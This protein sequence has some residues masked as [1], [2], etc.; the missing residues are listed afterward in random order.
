ML[1]L[2]SNPFGP[3]TV[4]WRRALI[5]AACLEVVL[6]GGVAV[7]ILTPG[8]DNPLPILLALALQFPGSLLFTPLL[9]AL[10]ELFHSNAVSVVTSVLVVVLVEFSIFAVL[11]K[12]P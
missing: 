9:S 8:A 12:R 7:S 5:Q 1:G 6:A 11:F 3:Q 4:S 2:E 10:H